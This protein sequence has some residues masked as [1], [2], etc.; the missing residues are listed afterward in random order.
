MHARFAHEAFSGYCDHAS[1]VPIDDS[2][3]DDPDYDFK[4]PGLSY[5]DTPQVEVVFEG[6]NER[7]DHGI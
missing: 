1:L 3:I 2:I 4:I 7:Q 6:C 5:A